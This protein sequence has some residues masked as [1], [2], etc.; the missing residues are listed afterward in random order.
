MVY[1]LPEQ[2]SSAEIAGAVAECLLEDLRVNGLGIS[3]LPQ[4]F[5]P[6]IMDRKAPF[7]V[8]LAWKVDA[9]GETVTRAFEMTMTEA[10]AAVKK[11]KAKT[12]YDRALFERVQ[13]AIAKLEGLAGDR[14][15]HRTHWEPPAP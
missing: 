3:G 14:E 11:F 13:K 8:T 15:R 4:I 9:H 7:T 1:Y 10:K 2:I 5:I 6:S 12:G